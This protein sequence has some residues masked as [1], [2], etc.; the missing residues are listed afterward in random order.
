MKYDQR[1][2]RLEESCSTNDWEKITY[3]LN[4]TTTTELS[5]HT[6][7]QKYCNGTSTLDKICGPK[8]F[9]VALMELLDLNYICLQDH[10]VPAF[11]YAC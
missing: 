6:S 2:A 11:Y 3:Y 10:R 7:L 8:I 9:G 1:L 4:G 5:Y